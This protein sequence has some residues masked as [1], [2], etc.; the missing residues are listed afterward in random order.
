MAT[1]A[2]ED[3]DL[4]AKTQVCCQRDGTIKA[5]TKINLYNGFTKFPTDISWFPKKPFTL[6]PAAVVD[7][8]RKAHG[9]YVNYESTRFHTLF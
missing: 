7:A 2:E 1:S 5:H 3:L 4:F 6:V 9:C 8:T